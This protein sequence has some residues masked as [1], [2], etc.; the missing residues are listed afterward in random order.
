M[1]KNPQKLRKLC[2][3][4]FTNYHSLFFRTDL[5]LIHT[6][7]VSCL[8]WANP[9][10]IHSTF[11]AQFSFFPFFEQLFVSIFL[12][13]H[14]KLCFVMT[15]WLHRQPSFNNFFSR[16]KTEKTKQ[17]L[18]RHIHRRKTCGKFICFSSVLVWVIPIISC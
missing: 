1:K 13:L 5:C 18:R 2:G 9:S 15:W 3:F 7:C 8:D 4:H 12:R 17:N 10:M 16:K 11:N 6:L 14:L